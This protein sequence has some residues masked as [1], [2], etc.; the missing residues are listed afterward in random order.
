MCHL[1]I[2]LRC[3]VCIYIY[4]YV[5]ICICLCISISILHV[6]SFPKSQEKKFFKERV[7][8]RVKGCKGGKQDWDLKLSIG[9]HSLSKSVTSVAKEV[10]K[11]WYYISVLFR[12]LFL[13]FCSVTFS[14]RPEGRLQWIIHEKVSWETE[15][16]TSETKLEGHRWIGGWENH[17]FIIKNVRDLCLFIF[18]WEDRVWEEETNDAKIR[19]DN[20]QRAPEEVRGDGIQSTEGGH[21]RGHSLV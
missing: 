21:P 20:R 13:F 6:R 7:A 5:C 8:H 15:A 19:S 11:D 17:W 18:W 10:F 14:V 4:I 2:Y 16:M 1:Y 9:G 3:I 12:V